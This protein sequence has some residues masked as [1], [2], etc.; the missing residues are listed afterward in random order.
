MAQ[1]FRNSITR[2]TGTSNVDILPEAS[3]DSYDAVI[4]IRLANVSGDSITVSVKLVRSSTDY[5]II[6]N[7]E[8]LQGQ[9]LELIDGGS[10]IVL[11]DNDKLVA[12]SNAPTSL[13][14]LVSYIDEIST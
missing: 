4:G 3:V 10:K 2:N 14:C 5:Y 9:S 11:H 7:V 13:D 6:K 8:I 12:I 1:N